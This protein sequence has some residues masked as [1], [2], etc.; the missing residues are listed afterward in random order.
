MSK[1]P[2]EEPTD[3][4]DN[5]IGDA[6]DFQVSLAH[7]DACVLPLSGD[8]EC[9]GDTEASACATPNAYSESAAGAPSNA[10]HVSLGKALHGCAVTS[11][12][13]IECW[14]LGKTKTNVD[15]EYGQAINPEVILLAGGQR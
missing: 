14:G 13:A 9:W 4:N 2:D 3:L 10:T 6:C 1:S 11:E 8:V 5:N 15:P 12:G 7:Y